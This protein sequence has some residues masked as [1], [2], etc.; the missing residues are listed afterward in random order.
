MAKFTILININISIFIFLAHLSSVVS[1]TDKC[2]DQVFIVI[3][4]KYIFLFNFDSQQNHSS[5]IIYETKANTT[6]ENGLFN[7]RT[8]TI[9]LLINQ[10]NEAYSIVALNVYD[11][12]YNYWKEKSNNIKYSTYIY[13]SVSQ[14]YLYVLNNQTMLLQIFALPLTLT[15]YKQNYL[16]DL[17]KNQTILNYV[18]DEK[19]NFLYILFENFQYQ[20]YVCQLKTYH[21]NLY[22]NSIN[23]YK[24]V[25]LYINWIYQKL[26]INSKDSLIIFDYNQ[27]HTDYIIHDLNSTKDNENQFLTICEKT[28]F[29]EYISIDYTN[30]QQVC[31]KTCQY[32]PLIL[33]DTDRIHTIQRISILSNIFYCS[34]QRQIAKIIIMILILIDILTILGVIIW[35]AYKYFYQST[36]NNN[37]NK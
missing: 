4:T 8:N 21:C 22:M 16:I 19:L 32:L 33:N 17:P 9:I 1:I 30:K 36:L 5:S 23:S 27:N 37:N 26:Y 34:R 28:N 10:L 18:I 35:L 14:R 29:I 15:P 20:L 2:D 6:I 13:I 12:I 25:Q 31:L 3:S 7:K 11:T 24:P